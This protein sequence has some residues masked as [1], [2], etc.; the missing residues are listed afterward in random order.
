MEMKCK[1]N[2]KN[3]DVQIKKMCENKTDNTATYV[4]PRSTFLA[5]LSLAV[6]HR[7]DE[8]GEQYRE[9]KIARD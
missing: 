1:L 3:D 5:A 2:Q 9:T 6:S 4:S 8:R 7:L